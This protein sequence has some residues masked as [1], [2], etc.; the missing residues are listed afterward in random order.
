[1][2]LWNLHPGQERK[3]VAGPRAGQPRPINTV[4]LDQ[5]TALRQAAID[6]AKQGYTVL[7]LATG[8][9]L[10]T[11]E[12]EPGEL[13]DRALASGKATYYR[14]GQREDLADQWGQLNEKPHG[15]RVI[16]S[17]VKR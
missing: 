6:L 13:T 12:V 5:A 9:T 11:I 14:K 16:F 2:I 10:P 7:A 4:V 8:S 17:E 1:M 3:I 15:V